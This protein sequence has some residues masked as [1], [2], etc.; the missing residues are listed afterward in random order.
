MAIT[1]AV[2]LVISLAVATALNVFNARYA[3]KGR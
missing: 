1:M 2:Y 3:L